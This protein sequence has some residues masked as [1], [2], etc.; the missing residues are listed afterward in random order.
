MDR[1]FTVF[2]SMG[3]S[4]SSLMDAELNDV[5]DEER[6]TYLEYFEERL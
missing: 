1:H 5:E 6:N 3:V 2:K 4:G